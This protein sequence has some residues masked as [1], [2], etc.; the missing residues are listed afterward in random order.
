[1]VNLFQYKTTTTVQ[2]FSERVHYRQHLD[3]YYE[4]SKNI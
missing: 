2:N 1:M 4:Y 3:K